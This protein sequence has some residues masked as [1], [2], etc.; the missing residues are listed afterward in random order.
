[1]FE[2]SGHGQLLSRHANTIGPHAC[3]SAL[4]RRKDHEYPMTVLLKIN[5]IP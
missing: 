1:M 3:P 2:W 5:K 4:Y